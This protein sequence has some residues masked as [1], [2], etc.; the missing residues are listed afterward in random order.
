MKILF[1]G[2]VF[3]K[4]G[5]KA[6]EDLLPVLICRHL[7][8]LVIANIENAAHGSGISAQTLDFFN[9]QE[10][11]VYTT[12]NH[13]LEKPDALELLNNEPKLIRPANY[14]PGFPGRGYA[15]FETRKRVKVAVVNLQ[16]TVFMPRIECPFRTM[17]RILNEIGSSTNLIFV[18][19]HAE[20][21]SEK[22][23]LGYYLDGRVSAVIGT[24]THVQTADEEILPKGTAFLSDAG[25]TGPH[26]SIIGMKKEIILEKFL[27]RLPQKFEPAAKG[28]ILCGVLVELDER[29]GRGIGILRI[30]ERLD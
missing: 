10:I 7:P 11:D 30:R 16:G 24:H 25:M 21:T 26:H 19:F 13:V 29:N 3:A 1:I 20:A 8:D 15:V 6:V 4:P 22:R 23:A 2:D 9:S 27:S 28:N 12:G 5:R 17:D 14:P 18:D